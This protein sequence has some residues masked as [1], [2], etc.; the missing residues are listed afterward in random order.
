MRSILIVAA[1]LV[2]TPVFAQQPDSYNPGRVGDKPEQQSVDMQAQKRFASWTDMKRDCYTKAGLVE[3]KTF[4]INPN[5]P[6][7]IQIHDLVWIK[8]G[9][10]RAAIAACKVKQLQ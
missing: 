10:D 9:F 5:D 8:P 3:G 6:T 7:D 1:L 2:A 4:R